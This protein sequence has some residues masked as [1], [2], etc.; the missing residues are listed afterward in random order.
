MWGSVL[1]LIIYLIYK[2]ASDKSYYNSLTNLKEKSKAQLWSYV[3]D[4]LNMVESIV[5]DRAEEIVKGAI[6]KSCNQACGMDSKGIQL[7][8]F[9]LNL[10]RSLHHH[11][12]EDIKTAIR[13]NGFHKMSGVELDVFIQ[14]KASSLIIKARKRVTSRGNTYLNII[15]SSVCKFSEQEARE[16]IGKIVKKSI[17]LQK[18]LDAEIRALNAKHSFLHKIMS[19]RKFFK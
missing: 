7:T 16:F 17:K 10:E 14:D 15:N 18:D 11:T 4:Q 3:S 13:V 8:M 1:L 19:I 5:M 2:K 12:F 6:I 9:S